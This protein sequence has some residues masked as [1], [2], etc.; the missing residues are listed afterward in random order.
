[1]RTATWTELSAIITSI[2]KVFHQMSEEEFSFKSGPDKWSRKEI[3]GHL[4]DSATNNHHRFVRS[5][6]EEVPIITY[7]QNNW[8]R[9][10]YYE[11]LGK[12][13]LIDFWTLYNKQILALMEQMPDEHLAKKCNTGGAEPLTIEYL[14]TDYVQHIKHHLTQIIP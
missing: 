5:Q 14:F 9:F 13:Q 7:E 3:L 1:M 11:H 10:N 6:F 4:I 2:P 8:N 12:Q